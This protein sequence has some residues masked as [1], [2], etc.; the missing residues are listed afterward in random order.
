MIKIY[1]KQ[2]QKPQIWKAAIAVF[3][4]LSSLSLTWTL[5]NEPVQIAVLPLGLW[6]L[7]AILRHRGSWVTYRKFA[8][9]GFFAN[10]LFVLS[11]L[12]NHLLSS[13]FY[14]TNQLSTYLA[15]VKDAQL[16]AVHP[17]AQASPKL[18][19]PQSFEG[20]TAVP[21]ESY[22]A[23]DWY[24]EIILEHTTPVQEKFPYILLDTQAKQGSGIQPTI[25]VEANGKGLLVTNKGKQFYFYLQ[26]SMIGEVK[27][28]D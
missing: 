22:Y 15:D 21:S 10:Y 16:L 17:S 28:D 8:W 19:L 7:L 5:F 18:H 2:E 25:F 24:N 3:V 6:V 26:D 4:G 23:L 9:L 27:T 12:L 13:F 1:Q 20:I 11:F 14:P